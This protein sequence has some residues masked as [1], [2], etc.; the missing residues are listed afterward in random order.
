MFRRTIL[1]MSMGLAALGANAANDPSV[2]LVHG[3]FAD[4]SDWAKVI[5]LLQA[6]GVKVRAVQNG[7]N[8]LADDVATTRRA[9]EA[10]PGN[11]VLV[12]HSWGGSVITE[13]G[14]N[15]KVAA[16]VYVAAFAPDVGQTTAEVGKDY[17][18]SPGMREFVVDKAGYLSLSQQGME[19]DFA[20]DVPAA[21]GRVMAAT[22][23]AINSK[24]FDERISVAAWKQKPSWYIV[25]ERDRMIAPDLQ[26]ALARKINAT[27]TALPTSHVPHQ[28]RPA[29][30]AR[31]ITEALNTTR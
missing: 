24:A 6:N 27:T 14:A 8:S 20:P 5:T 13:A 19:Q 7:L 4:G 28:S 31:V 23:G 25:S 29:D 30:V 12:G 3:A 11:V 16:L 17:P 22:Q 21:Q 9:I 2:V 1:A 18:P 26:R 15:D 10:A